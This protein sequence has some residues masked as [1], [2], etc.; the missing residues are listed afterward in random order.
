MSASGQGAFLE[1]AE[2]LFRVDVGGNEPDDVVFL[3]GVLMV[4][5]AAH[6]HSI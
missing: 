3:E 1:T 6:K 5:L 4:C 2:R